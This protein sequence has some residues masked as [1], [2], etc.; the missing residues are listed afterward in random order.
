MGVRGAGEFTKAPSFKE[1]HGLKA[2]CIAG[3][4]LYKGLAKYV[5]MDI[6][7]VKGAN[8]KINSNLDGM[9]KE[10]IKQTKN[11]D[12][13]FLHMK[14]ADSLAEIGDYKGKKEFIERI[15]KSFAPFLKAKDTVIFLSGDHSTP[16]K[17]ETHSGDPSPAFIWGPKEIIRTDKVNSF[18]ERPCQEGGLGH[19]KGITLMNELLNLT[20]KQK[21]TGA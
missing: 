16:C 1:K 13:V 11:Y 8:G 10:A 14:F 3:A 18:G 6:I 19:F 15:D 2:C 7:E 12:L 17:M 4:G 20:N 9:A 5:G 21:L